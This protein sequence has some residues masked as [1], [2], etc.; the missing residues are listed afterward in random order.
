MSK[1]SGDMAGSCGAEWA[2]L[3]REPGEPSLLKRMLII[4]SA[5]LLNIEILISFLLAGDYMMIVSEDTE[6]LISLLLAD[7]EIHVALP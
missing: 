5:W 3:F 2:Y 6:I 1:R 7:D 4:V